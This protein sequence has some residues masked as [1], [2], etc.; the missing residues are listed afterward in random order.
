V[1]MDQDAVDVYIAGPGHSGPGIPEHKDESKSE[2]KTEQKSENTPSDLTEQ[3]K[4]R[5]QE[6]YEKR[7]RQEGHADEDWSQA[8]KEIRKEKNK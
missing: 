5:A 8:E 7:G 4:K 6:L 1:H 2:D 3:I